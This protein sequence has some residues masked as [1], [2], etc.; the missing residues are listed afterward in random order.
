MSA[1]RI[2]YLDSFKTLLIFLVV[3]G[4]CLIRLGEGSLLIKT[5]L[6]MIYSVHMPLFVFVSGYFS[7]PDKRLKDSCW[8]L[9]AAFVLFQV[10]WII[11][12]PPHSL[13]KIMSPVTTLWYLLSLCYWR[14]LIKVFDKIS[15]SK[16]L[17]LLVS[18]VL[19]IVAGYIPLSTELSFQRTFAFFP[20]FVMGNMMRDNDLFKIRCVNKLLISAVVAIIIAGAIGLYIVQPNLM[21]LLYGKSPYQSYHTSLVVAPIVKVIWLVLTSILCLMIMIIVPDLAILSKEGAK[22]LTVYLF[23]FFPIYFLQKVG[24]H[25]DNLFLL[26]VIALAIYCFTSLIH[27]FKIIKWLTCPIYR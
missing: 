14:L 22:T 21:W 1:S 13:S 4:H 23:H 11:I 8:G 17:W 24:F 5:S 18:V 7:R 26:I 19:M 2:T 10:I 6:L 27:R 12:N 9:F 20:F 25:S 3:L 15:K 16:T